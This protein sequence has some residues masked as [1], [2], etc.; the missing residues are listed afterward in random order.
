MPTG[1]Y[2]RTAKHK[3][4]LRGLTHKMPDIWYEKQKNRTDRRG[5]PK[6]TKPWNTG[7]K[8]PEVSG[9]KHYNWKGGITSENRKQRKK[10]RIEVQPLVLKRDNYTC[11]VCLT[12]G[13]Y[14]QVDHIKNWAD[15][16]ELRFNLDNCQT[17]C[18]SCHYKVTF[19]RDMPEG[20]V[21]GHKLSEVM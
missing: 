13:G 6:G 2:E 10:F 4:A 1:V 19:G 7:K 20:T 17:L 3:Q 9:D 11:R 8:R 21:W 12:S 18:M 14:L 5:A 16:P 15:Y